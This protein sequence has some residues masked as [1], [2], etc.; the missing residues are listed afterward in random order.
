MLT[1]A[2]CEKAVSF[3][4]SARPT[5]EV[6]S[7]QDGS[8]LPKGPLTAA[9]DSFLTGGQSRIAGRE[10]LAY[11]P[12][13]NKVESEPRAHAKH[14]KPAGHSLFMGADVAELTQRNGPNFVTIFRTGV[15]VC[16]I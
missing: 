16:S 10:C 12:V 8:K 5:V 7:K 15:R 11:L 9:P 13:I 14:S 1:P 4:E 6:S 3:G 2:Q